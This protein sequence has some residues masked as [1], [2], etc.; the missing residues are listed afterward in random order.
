MRSAEK[1]E[2]IVGGYPKLAEVLKDVGE[3]DVKIQHASIVTFGCIRLLEFEDPGPSCRFPVSDY[4]RLSAKVRRGEFETLKT[5]AEILRALKTHQNIFDIATV[6]ERHSELMNTSGMG[7]LV[8]GDLFSLK[9]RLPERMRKFR[10]VWAEET[11]PGEEFEVFST[12]SI[13]AATA[14]IRDYPTRTNIG[15]EY[16]E[17]VREQIEKVTLFKSPP[18]GPSPIHPN[19]YV[20]AC[21]NISRET[22]KGARTYVLQE[23]AFVVFD[24]DALAT[25]Q[26]IT[27]L[28][29]KLE[30][31]LFD[32]YQQQLSRHNLINLEVEIYN[33]FEDVASNVRQLSETGWWHL[34]KRGTYS[35]AAR[36]SLSKIHT[37]LVEYGAASLYSYKSRDERLQRIKN[38]PLLG[39]IH[40][41]FASMSEGE[42][43]PAKALTP[44]LDYFGKELQAFGSIRSVIIASFLSAIAGAFF[45]ALLSRLLL[46]GPTH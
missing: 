5:H 35:A 40:Q 43:G 34:L 28:F 8:A 26:I 33:H 36:T 24:A 18:I 17:L 29:Q 16:R 7:L 20:V 2:V 13:F 23:D 12:G 6:K 3:A 25:R 10:G 22:S 9:V 15:H 42:A 30:H 11:V 32:F 14:P 27:N 46:P 21:Q 39:K 4:E 45:Y 1:A 19:F 38:D 41:Y 31:H 37:R 44:A